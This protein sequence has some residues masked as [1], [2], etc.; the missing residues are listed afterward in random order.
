MTKTDWYLDS[1]RTEVEQLIKENFVGNIDFK[2]NFSPNGITNVMIGLNN[3][4]K[5]PDNLI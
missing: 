4:I 1:I 3:S 2:F 5:A